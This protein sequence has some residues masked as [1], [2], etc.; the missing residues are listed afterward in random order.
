M[1]ARPALFLDRDGVINVDHGYVYQ[2][3]DCDFVSGVFELVKKANQKGYLVLVVTNQSGI[4]RGYYTEQDF[5]DFSDWQKNQFEL[6]SATIDYIYFCPHHPTTGLAPYVKD[7]DCRKPNSGMFKT[8]AKD[9]TIDF[10]RSVM[11]GDK[12]TDMIA[13]DHAGVKNLILFHQDEKTLPPRSQDLKFL[14]I[15]SLYKAIDILDNL[16][17]A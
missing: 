11:I 14:T 1:Q 15:E 10:N 7:C 2:S 9:F 8:A 13:A 17:Y 5:R 6:H 16:D 12:V 3:K 4:A